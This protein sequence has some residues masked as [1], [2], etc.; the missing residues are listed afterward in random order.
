MKP[1]TVD[2]LAGLARRR[3]HVPCELWK[4]GEG[5]PVFDPE[6][7]QYVDP[8]DELVYEG[9]SIF[10]PSTEARVVEFGEGPVVLNTFTVWMPRNTEAEVGWTFMVD[11][12]GDDHLDGRELVVIDVPYDPWGPAR[13]ITVEGQ[14]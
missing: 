3:M 8:P 7:G 1:G 11:E 4:P 6:T 10:R 12:S 2:R 14:S 13:R 5:E 9:G